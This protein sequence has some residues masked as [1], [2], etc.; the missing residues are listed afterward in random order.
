[1]GVSPSEGSRCSDAHDYA[2][3]R[4][5][6]RAADARRSLTKASAFKPADDDLPAGWDQIVTSFGRSKRKP[7]I[8]GLYCFTNDLKAQ[9]AKQSS[10]LREVEWKTRQ[11]ETD[12]EHARQK[13]KEAEVSQQHADKLIDRREKIEAQSNSRQAWLVA[14]N[15][16]WAGATIVAGGVYY[17]DKHNTMPPLPKGLQ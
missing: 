3:E 12:S 6:E 15:M 1:M 4:A 8:T 14:T 9:L 10:A 16:V 13:W 5:Q 7:I 11:A 2:L 17:I